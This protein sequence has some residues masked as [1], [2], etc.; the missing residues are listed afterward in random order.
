MKKVGYL[1]QAIKDKYNGKIIFII[2]YRLVIFF[3]HALDR[4]ATYDILN[5]LCQQ[6]LNQVHVRTVLLRTFNREAFNKKA[7][8]STRDLSV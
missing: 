5:I 8:L 1:I 7:M 4:V 2:L 6:K 3:V